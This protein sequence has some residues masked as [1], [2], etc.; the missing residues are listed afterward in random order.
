MPFSPEWADMKTVIGDIVAYVAPVQKGARGRG[1]RA[2]PNLA[3]LLQSRA[4]DPAEEE[5]EKRFDRDAEALLDKLVTKWNE[6]GAD[7][8]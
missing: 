2:R 6:P 5:N 7:R 3:D 1:N 8:G 4:L